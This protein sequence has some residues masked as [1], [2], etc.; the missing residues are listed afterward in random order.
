MVG[1]FLETGGDLDLLVG[2]ESGLRLAGDS[3]RKPSFS[4]E[5]PANLFL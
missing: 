5:G 4:E 2:R 3:E 1:T